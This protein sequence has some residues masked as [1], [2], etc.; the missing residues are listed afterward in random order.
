MKSLR[1][2]TQLLLCGGVLGLT[3]L[4][5]SPASAS[6]KDELASAQRMI[7][8]VQASLERARVTAAQADPSERGRYFFDYQRANDDLKTISTGIDRY[9]EP[10][11]AQPRDLSGVAGNYRRERP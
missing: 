4:A 11:R 7:V 10:T 6:E 8:Q 3:F 5:S 9:L 1:L 2:A